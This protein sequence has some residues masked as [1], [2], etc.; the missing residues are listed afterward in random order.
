MNQ[1]VF[2]KNWWDLAQLQTD[3]AN[4]LAFYDA[5]FDYA[6]A[7]K[8][9]DEVGRDGDKALRAARFAFLTVQP[10]LDLS[11]KRSAAGAS[12]VEARRIRTANT[13]QNTKLNT[14]P[15]TKLNT[16]PNTKLNTPPNT[17]LK[18]RIEENRIEENRIVDASASTGSG[19]C[20]LP[21]REVFLS[22][23]E[24]TLGVPRDFADF[25]YAE[26]S[27]FDGED[28]AG[29]KIGSWRRYVKAAWE[30][31]RKRAVVAGSPDV[32]P[33]KISEDDL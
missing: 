25:V 7:G 2:Y 16:P 19:G 17:K 4:R 22:T 31:S 6:F 8:V 14:P 10:I 9:Q 20:R 11:A 18:N 26:L 1:I 3:D 30:K 5:I 27:Q 32:A 12:S 21:S 33:R 23:C 29:N 13:P 15:N 28:A 24:S